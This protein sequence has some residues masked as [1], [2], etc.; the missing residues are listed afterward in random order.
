M[1]G[2][3]PPTV[4]ALYEQTSGKPIPTPGA[5]VMFPFKTG[6]RS[7]DVVPKRLQNLPPEQQY[8]SRTSQTA[9]WW[10][11]LW[12]ASPVKVDR[13]IKTFTGG[14]GADVLALIDSMVY[15]SGMA[16]D[17]RPDDYFIMGKFVA[18]MVPSQTKYAEEFYSKLEAA[19]Y[20]KERDKPNDLKDLNKQNTKISKALREYR[21]IEDSN[22]DPKSKKQQLQS[23][24]RYINSLYKDAIK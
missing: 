15:A 10:G 16:E 18:D 5:T 13:L 21:D 4:T 1:A 2:A 3:Y 11:S 8:T 17:K 14:S 23:Q 7:P 9:I 22:A 6:K 19:H 24:Q 12:G 20:D